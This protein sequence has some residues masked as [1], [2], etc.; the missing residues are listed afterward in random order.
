MY[1]C[2]WGG[3]TSK[4]KGHQG[5]SVMSVVAWPVPPTASR[6]DGNPFSLPLAMTRCTHLGAAPNWPRQRLPAVCEHTKVVHSTTITKTP[7]RGATSAQSIVRPMLST[8]TS[9]CK[10]QVGQ[11]ETAAGAGL[12]CGRR[13]GHGQAKAAQQAVRARTQAPK[14][15]VCCSRRARGPSNPA[16]GGSSAEGRFRLSCR[17]GRV[18]GEGEGK[19]EGD[20]EHSCVYVCV[21][22]CV[23]VRARV[24]AFVCACVCVCE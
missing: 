7:R 12:G 5:A 1:V 17:A 2:V 22:V 13:R 19:T 3:E 14:A 21:C 23:C 15:V 24:C 10:E 20:V 18:G 9:S 16:E 8:S 6:A 4:M 11:G